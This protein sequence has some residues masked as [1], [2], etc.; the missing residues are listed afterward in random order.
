MKF[1][2]KFINFVWN[3]IY[4]PSRIHGISAA[5]EEIVATRRASMQNLIYLRIL[6]LDKLR[7]NCKD[8][9]KVNTR[10]PIAEKSA[11]HNFPLGALNDCTHSPALVAWAERNF[12]KP[13][14]Y[15]DLGCAG[16]GLIF[17]FIMANHSAVGIEGS[18]VSSDSAAGFWPALKNKALFTADITEEFQVTQNNAPTKFDLITAWEVLEHIYPK[19]IEQLFKNVY[20]HLNDGGIF[21]ASVAQFQSSD[22]IHGK[23][24]HVNFQS[25]KW[26]ID[27]LETCGFRIV[28]NPPTWVMARGSG[29]KSAADW[30]VD[31]NPSLGFHLAATI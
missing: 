20:N 29:N 1:R 31:I 19:Q 25:K 10:F 15:L 11:D 27:Q 8:D 26:W 3:I 9:F 6:M 22:P 5:V 12:T 14:Y 18:S 17:D 4:L 24:L 2:L 7:E 23:H 28:D 30:N 16:G 21:L 13:I